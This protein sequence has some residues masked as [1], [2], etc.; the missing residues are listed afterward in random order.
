MPLVDGNAESPPAATVDAAQTPL[1][2]TDTMSVKL[3]HSLL[4]MAAKPYEPP[5]GGGSG[6]GSGGP[7]GSGSPPVGGS[8]TRPGSRPPSQ[9][10]ATSPAPPGTRPGGG[11][12]AR[13][14]PPTDPV[15]NE[16]VPVRAEAA[17]ARK[18]LA[19]TGTDHGNPQ[20]GPQQPAPGAN[21]GLPQ[22]TLGTGGGDHQAQVATGGALKTSA[23]SN[24]NN[25]GGIGGGP[26]AGSGSGGGGSGDPPGGPSGG[27]GGSPPGGSGGGDGG[28][29]GGLLVG[30]GGFILRG[31]APGNQN[32]PMGT[33]Q[34]FPASEPEPPAP[35]IYN[36]RGVSRPNPVRGT[37]G[38]NNELTNTGAVAASPEGSA[39][40]IHTPDSPAPDEP[41][42]IPPAASEPPPA[43]SVLAQLADEAR[44]ANDRLIEAGNELRR[45]FATFFSLIE[46]GQDTGAAGEEI[47]KIRAKID[48]LWKT[49]KN[50]QALY[51]AAREG[52]ASAPPG[53]EEPAGA[54]PAEAPGDTNP[55]GYAA[56]ARIRELARL[57]DEALQALKA[58]NE[59]ANRL[60]EAKRNLDTAMAERRGVLDAGAEHDAAETAFEEAQAAY[61]AAGAAYDTALE[62]PPSPRPDEPPPASPSEPPAPDTSVFTV[63]FQRV[64]TIAGAAEQALRNLKAL[65]ENIFPGTQ[66]PEERAWIISCMTP[67]EQ[68]SYVSAQMD[69]AAGVGKFIEAMQ[70]TSLGKDLLGIMGKRFENLLNDLRTFPG[71][72]EVANIE[73]Q[74]PSDKVFQALAEQRYNAQNEYR[75]DLSHVNERRLQIVSDAYQRAV[76]RLGQA[77]VE[78]SDAARAAEAA[79][80]PGIT[81]QNQLRDGIVKLAV[82]EARSLSED[83]RGILGAMCDKAR[84][85]DGVLA[86]DPYDDRTIAAVEKLNQQIK[87]LLDYQNL[88]RRQR[89]TQRQYRRKIVIDMVTRALLG[90]PI[91]LEDLKTTLES[92]ENI[93]GRASQ[94]TLV[95]ETVPTEFGIYS[96][97]DRVI[98][99]LES[100]LKA[101]SEDQYELRHS[102]YKL[103]AFQK[104]IV[105]SN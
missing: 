28:G 49:A 46:R 40:G 35:S 32:Q 10:G 24:N 29:G 87:E 11:G 42:Q 33:T 5:P 63:E 4:E 38:N 85:A 55:P 69:A 68:L 71:V 64:D 92:Y 58:R 103:R 94:N 61:A 23:V 90:S 102:I 78:T 82:A 20:I 88:D 59:A 15:Q 47:A 1:R 60:D 105:P 21:N 27:G 91:N 101:K 66:T 98:D 25:G 2:I 54:A 37:V 57:S 74:P 96:M 3:L 6:G 62:H 12:V 18:S 72:E 56:E 9:A 65:T 70:N 44:A 7:H 86:E 22:T 16:N 89:Q 81:A 39:G 45:A 100:K 84:I 104:N 26:A 14:H 76:R 93:T 80:L 8:E 67:E 41:G 53:G 97:L 83:D 95:T 34:L 77:T 31:N 36:G 43:E 73:V 75:K 51:D 99:D 48:G 19:R 50:A 52:Q 30:R 13:L 79:V 17:T